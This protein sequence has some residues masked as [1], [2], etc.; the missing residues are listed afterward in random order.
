LSIIH[1]YHLLLD[2]VSTVGFETGKAF[3]NEVGHVREKCLTGKSERLFSDNIA[4][5]AHPGETS[6]CLLEVLRPRF[7]IKNSG[8]VASVEIVGAN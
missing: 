6:D 2:A 1:G 3:R 7:A 8:C 4:I 5:E